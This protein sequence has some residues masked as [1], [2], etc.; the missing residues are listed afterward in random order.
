MPILFFLAVVSGQ[1]KLASLK[2]VTLSCFIL[3]N[4]IVLISI[5]RGEI[6]SA[7][8]GTRFGSLENL[9]RY[10]LSIFGFSDIGVGT[11]EHRLQ[12]WSET[13]DI[14]FSSFSSFIFG[15]GY[16]V[17]IS[18]V[19][20]R[21]VHNGYLSILFRSGLIGLLVFLLFMLKAF[22]RIY[23][24]DNGV[25]VAVIVMALLDSFTGTLLDSP[26]LSAPIY[27]LIGFSIYRVSIEEKFVESETS[28]TH[29]LRLSAPRTVSNG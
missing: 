14:I 29:T 16:S 22:L 27:F 13:I 18:D 12:M 8:A 21:N 7:L 17:S 20:F 3:L 10:I 5:F 2:F 9:D 15:Q 28:K 23:R 19:A 4:F 1:I 24:K 6:N 26:F 11:R 25:M